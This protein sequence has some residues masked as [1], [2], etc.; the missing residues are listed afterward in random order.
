[1]PAAAAAAAAAAGISCRP[2]VFSSDLL[3]FFLL[4]GSLCCVKCC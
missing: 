2:T 3:S 4:E 1:M